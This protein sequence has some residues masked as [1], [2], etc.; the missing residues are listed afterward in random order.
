MNNSHED[1]EIEEEVDKKVL[2]E[3]GE[4]NPSPSGFLRCYST[5]KLRLSGANKISEWN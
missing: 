4:E 1:I 2:L 3:V 5:S